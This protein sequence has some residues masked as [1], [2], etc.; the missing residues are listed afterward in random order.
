MECQSF[1]I[2]AALLSTAFK[3]GGRTEPFGSAEARGFYIP[4]H[5]PIMLW[6]SCRNPALLAK[7]VGT[8]ELMSGGAALD[9]RPR[10]SRGAFLSCPFGGRRR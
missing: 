1:Q 10:R 7:M 6:P 8:L 3:S 9:T 2:L 4:L 5:G